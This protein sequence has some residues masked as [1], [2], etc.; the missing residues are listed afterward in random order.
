MGLKLAPK[1]LRGKRWLMNVD[2]ETIWEY[3]KTWA[4]KPNMKEVSE[5]AALEKMGYRLPPKPKKPKEEEPEDVSLDE[6]LEEEGEEDS[7]T[8]EDSEDGDSD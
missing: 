5:P 2:Q 8:S 4:K 7:E 6:M 3:D 1:E